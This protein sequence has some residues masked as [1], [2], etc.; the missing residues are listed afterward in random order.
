MRALF[1]W[2][3]WFRAA[4]RSPRFNAQP[5]LTRGTFAELMANADNGG[6]IRLGTSDRNALWLFC[7]AHSRERRTL[8]KHLDHLIEF[9]SIR[10]HD[11]GWEVVN[12]ADYQA[13][14]GGPKKR[15][16]AT[17]TGRRRDSGATTTERWLD[18]GATLAEHSLGPKCAESHA[19]GRTDR[20]REREV[21]GG[22]NAPPERARAGGPDDVR[23]M[24]KGAFSRAVESVGGIPDLRDDREDHHAAAGQLAARVAERDSVEARD[25]LEVWARGWVQAHTSRSPA[26]WRAYCRDQAAGKGSA[27]KRTDRVEAA[28]IDP[29]SA[30]ESWAE[31]ERVIGGDGG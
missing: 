2:I 16:A 30:A 6:W 23:R 7:G 31:F 26:S 8:N 13:K 18:T 20:E 29:V 1:P 28:V 10:C 25:V 9:G 22:A 21:E 11:D 24:A 27:R 4:V 14:S 12:F 19:P 15:A 3:K 17:V 5:F